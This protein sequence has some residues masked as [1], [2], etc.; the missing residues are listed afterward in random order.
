MASLENRQHPLKKVTSLCSTIAINRLWS[1]VNY[2]AAAYIYKPTSA[3]AMELSSPQFLLLALL[4][5]LVTGEIMSCILLASLCQQVRELRSKYLKVWL[6][7]D[8]V[9][10]RQDVVKAITLLDGL[11]TAGILKL[12]YHVMEVM[13]SLAT[14]YK[15]AT[16]SL[17][18]P[19]EVLI[20][21]NI[22]FQISNC[23]LLY[24]S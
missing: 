2:G 15:I 17:E 3:A 12:P 1:G 5:S 24:I 8:F 14:K 22:S 18:L 7:E 20:S 16:V 23:V 10:P 11:V 9:F 13:S 21:N 19:S 6:T 4:N